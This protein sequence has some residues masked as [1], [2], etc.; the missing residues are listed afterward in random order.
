MLTIFMEGGV[1][2][3]KMGQGL[4][5]VELGQVEHTGEHHDGY[6][7]HPE[8]LGV[9]WNFGN[10]GVLCYFENTSNN[11]DPE[12]LGVILECFGRLNTQENITMGTMYT[13]KN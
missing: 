10:F 6:N 3:L 1:H 11:V 12:Q 13:L 9:L 5:L 2:G 4:Q 7:V 8:Q